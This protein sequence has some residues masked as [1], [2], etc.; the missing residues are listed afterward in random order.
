MDNKDTDSV[1]NYSTFQ[2]HN[3]C[4]GGFCLDFKV[5]KV[6]YPAQLNIKEIKGKKEV[7]VYQYGSMD[8]AFEENDLVKGICSLH[9]SFIAPQC[10]K[11]IV[12][13]NVV[14]FI[15]IQSM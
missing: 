1:I 8:F 12:N 7:Y 15:A 9:Q 11:I 2:E 14:K 4:V 3:L 10:K 5:V 6:P 13:V